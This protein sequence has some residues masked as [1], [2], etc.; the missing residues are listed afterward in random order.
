[1]CSTNMFFP[2]LFG[3]LGRHRAAKDA[4]SAC[5][6]LHH[7]ACLPEF[8]NTLKCHYAF[9]PV[10]SRSPQCQVNVIH[11]YNTIHWWV[12]VSDVFCLPGQEILVQRRVVDS[13][14][15][16]VALRESQ[17]KSL[18]WNPWIYLVNWRWGS[19]HWK[20]V[21]VVVQRLGQKNREVKRAWM[22]GLW[23]N[24]RMFQFRL[25]QY[26]SKEN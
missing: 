4:R 26:T 15:L 16:P 18:A 6:R 9:F 2:D 23:W 17:K 10:S 7:P 13:N 11:Q 24:L 1:M 20:W 12:F 14:Q 8:A 21:S 22:A 3:P 25:Q 5:R 19:S